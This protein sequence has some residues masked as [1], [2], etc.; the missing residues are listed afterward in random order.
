M[1][2]QL[3]TIPVQ[4]IIEYKAVIP[5]TAISTSAHT[6]SALI[7]GIPENYVV[8]GTMIKSVTTFAAAGLTSLTCSLAA[9][10]PNTILSDLLY[11][12]LSS[13]LTQVVTPKAFQISGPPNNNL[14]LGGSSTFSPATGLYFNGAHDVVAYFTALGANLNTLSAGVVEVTVQIRPLS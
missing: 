10:V 5:Y 8:C 9:F 13:E 6:Y 2:T 4:E 3:P 11:Y 12:G 14:S 7:V 1:F